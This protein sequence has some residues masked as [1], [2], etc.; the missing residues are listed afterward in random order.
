MQ[1]CKDTIINKQD[2]ISNTIEQY[3]NQIQELIDN[4]DTKIKD[5]DA[6]NQKILGEK[7]QLQEQLNI[8]Y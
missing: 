3:K 1:T 6:I 8:K 4:K 2:E 5:L 7:D